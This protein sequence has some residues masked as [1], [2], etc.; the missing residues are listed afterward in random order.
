MSSCP[1]SARPLLRKG[2]CRIIRCDRCH[3]GQESPTLV[4]RA[5]T[6]HA[7]L[8][9]NADSQASQNGFVTVARPGGHRCP[10]WRRARRYSRIK[11]HP[12]GFLATQ[13]DA[14]QPY[15]ILREHVIDRIY[16]QNVGY[17]EANL[18]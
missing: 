9:L 6:A 16:D 2:I 7:E 3:S 11:P 17:W 13:P 1:I 18:Q 5:R 4:A 10:P 15:Y 12:A 8:Q 14:Y